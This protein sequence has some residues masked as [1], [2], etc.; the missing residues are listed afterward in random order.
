[1][2]QWILKQ[3]ETKIYIRVNLK[4]QKKNRLPQTEVELLPLK[5][6]KG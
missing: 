1:M 5:S 6:S 2:N 4:I 3:T